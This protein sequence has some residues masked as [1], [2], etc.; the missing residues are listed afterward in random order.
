[1]TVEDGKRE[2]QQQMVRKA[3][4]R[5]NGQRRGVHSWTLAKVVQAGRLGSE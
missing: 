1:M 5:E 4:D 2:G 3:V